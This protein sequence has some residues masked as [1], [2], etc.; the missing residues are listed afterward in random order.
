MKYN[1]D[2]YCVKIRAKI[3]I[4]IPINAAGIFLLPNPIIIMSIPAI[5]NMTSAIKI[6]NSP[7]TKKKMTII[8]SRIRAIRVLPVNIIVIY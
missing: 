2:S 6:N 8:K 1:L 4:P 5:H 7:A 3:L